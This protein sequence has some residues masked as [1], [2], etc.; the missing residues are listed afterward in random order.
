MPVDRGTGSGPADG[1]Y[2]W[3]RA[4]QE[5]DYADWQTSVHGRGGGDYPQRHM[6]A[7][8]RAGEPLTVRAVALPARFG[9]IPAPANHRDALADDLY[10]RRRQNEA[11]TVH[12]DD[13]VTPAADDSDLFAEYRDL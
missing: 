9:G 7:K 11:L 13:R 5:Q 10:W 1:A 12:P 6:L 2:A 8:L 4:R 3:L